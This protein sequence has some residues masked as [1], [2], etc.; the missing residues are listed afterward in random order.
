MD[1]GLAKQPIHLSTKVVYCIKTLLGLVS[2]V[3]LSEQTVHYAAPIIV[4]SVAWSPHD[5]N[6]I[7][8]CSDD[9]TFKL[10]RMFQDTSDSS[11]VNGTVQRMKR[12]E[13][14]NV[15]SNALTGLLNL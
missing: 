1:G 12:N 3:Y 8:T 14:T 9:S 13:D 11:I 7:V 15:E 10:W 4:N 5:G 6:K 2:N